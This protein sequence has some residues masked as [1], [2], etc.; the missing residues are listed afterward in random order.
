MRQ[1][2]VGEDFT[3]LYGQCN[4]SYSPI[5]SAE[6]GTIRDTTS[7]NEWFVIRLSQTS[8]LL[9]LRCDYVVTDLCLCPKKLMFCVQRIVYKKLFV[10]IHFTI[11]DREV[12]PADLFH[13]SFEVGHEAGWWWLHKSLGPMEPLIL[14]KLQWWKRGFSLWQVLSVVIVV[15]ANLSH[16]SFGVG[17]ETDWWWLHKSLVP[18]LFGVPVWYVKI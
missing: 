3:H 12:V 5:F 1:V 17:H 18:S 9:C 14:T 11:M 16:A 4:H 15:L 6:K 10:V 8:R 7:T 13:A 2:D